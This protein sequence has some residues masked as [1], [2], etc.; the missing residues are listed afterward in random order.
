MTT[1]RLP[2]CCGRLIEFSAPADLPRLRELG[3]LTPDILILGGGSNL[4]FTDSPREDLT[5]VRPM[6]DSM[7]IILDRGN[8]VILRAE[9][10][11]VLDNLCQYAAEQG[12]WGVENLADIPGRIGGAAVQ[13]VGA[14]GAEFKDVVVGINCY[15]PLTGEFLTLSADECR[16]GYRDSIF[17]HLSAEE[18]LIV[19]SADILLTR[20][21]RP[22][23]KYKALAD[24]IAAKYDISALSPQA[25]RREVIALRQAKL[26]SPA[27]VGSAGSFFKNPVVSA[28]EL[29]KV[30]AR[31]KEY[32]PGQTLSYHL[33]PD[34]SAKLSAAW[35]IDKAGCKPLSCGG[36]SLW[37]SQPLVIVNLT[38]DA[39]G[40]DVVELE[41]VIISRVRDTFGVTLTPE[42]I[43]I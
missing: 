25:I 42:V 31:A 10:A 27:E 40:S 39:T 38:G 20:T 28:E 32:A 13:N 24:A 4:L 6:M 11:V 35:L 23:L 29:G 33:L 9:S 37:Q 34:G 7:E 18:R 5:V 19:C 1:F 22:N 30:E 43:H 8:E 26:P 15:R 36:A 16:Y 2:A 12:L 17:K 21:P 41:D 14:Y 3:V